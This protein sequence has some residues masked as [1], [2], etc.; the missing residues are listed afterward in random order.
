MPSFNGSL[1]NDIKWKAKY[2][3]HAGVTL[4]YSA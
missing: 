1:D 2:S 4:F 3:L